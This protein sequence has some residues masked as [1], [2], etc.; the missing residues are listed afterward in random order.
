MEL[1]SKR[2]DKVVK[3]VFDR[4]DVIIVATVPVSKVSLAETLKARPDCK[5]FVVTR[6]NRDGLLTE[7][8][9]QYIYS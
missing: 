4:N 2:F 8:M 3:A 9:L 5:T 6:E 1:F 7:E